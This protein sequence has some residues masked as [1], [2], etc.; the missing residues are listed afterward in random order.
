[1]E[2]CQNHFGGTLNTPPPK[3]NHVLPRTRDFS[4]KRVCG[5]Y[6]KKMFLIVQTYLGGQSNY[7]PSF[8]FSPPNPVSSW[9]SHLR[10]ES[11]E[12]HEAKKGGG[13]MAYGSLVCHSCQKTCLPPARLITV[14]LACSHINNLRRKLVL[15]PKLFSKFWLARGCGDESENSLHTADFQR[16][17]ML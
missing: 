7:S 13:F 14:G 9:P 2:S 15:A 16:R 4:R 1:M 11:R 8:L 5:F 6:Y 10:F 12:V 3:K 17:A